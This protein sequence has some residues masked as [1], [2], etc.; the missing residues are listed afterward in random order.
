ML[1]TGSGR[2]HGLAHGRA[3]GF[4]HGSLHS[5]CK[6]VYICDPGVKCMAHDG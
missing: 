2:A 6:C 5:A 4:A 1:C 3:H